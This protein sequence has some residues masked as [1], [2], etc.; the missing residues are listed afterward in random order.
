MKY[1]FDLKTLPQEKMDRAGGKASS[2]SL[3]MKN[4]KTNIPSGY[5]ITADGFRDGKLTD[6]ASEELNQTIAKLDRLK[7][8]AV[9]SSA[10]GEDGE[11]N[12]FAGQY[13]TLTDVIVPKIRDAVKQVAASAKSERVEEYKNRN[14]AAGEGIGIVIQE[15]V[16][17]DFAGVIFTSDIITGRDDKIVGNY[18]H[19]EGEKLVS[20]SEN[21]EEFRIGVMN[22]SYEGNPELAPYA[23]L[24][25]KYTLAIK[26]FYG[27]PMDI[28]WAVSRGKTYILQARPITTLRRIDP[29]TYDVNGTRSGYKLLTKTNVGEIF[30]KPV[31]PMTFSVLEKIND[32]LGLPDWLDCICGQEYMN[33]SVMCSLMV[34]FGKSREKAYEAVRE[35]VGEIPEGVE[36]PVSPFD[37]KAFMR[38]IRALLFPK[39]KSTLSKKEKHEMVLNLDRIADDLIIEVRKI[40]D[41]TA[42]MNYWDN[43]LVKYLN[44]GLAS[45]MT[46]S[47]TSLVPLF[48]TR[49]KIA[50][51]AGE[52]MANRL[53]TGCV[54][55]LDCMKP[56]LLLE[57][58]ASG[59]MTREEYISACG[60]RCAD[61]M[62]LMASRPYEDPT[63]PDALLKDLNASSS[64]LHQMQ[65]N[66]QKAY[67]EAV[68]EFKQKYPSKAKWFDKEIAKFIHANAFREDIRSKGV[69][70][71]CVFREYILKAGELNGLGDD[72]FMLSYDEMFALLKGDKTAL[73]YIP[74]R[75]ASL[76]KYNSYPGFPNLVVG[77]FDPDA[78]MA[79][80]GRRYDVFVSDRVGSENV[81]SDVK[82]FAG[83]AGVVTGTVRV[84]EDVSQIDEII[85]G[86]ILV[87][88]ATNIGWTVAF[89]KVSAIVTDI[90]APLS[91]AAIVAREFGIPAV[92]GC[93]NAT[94]VLKTGD[95]VT[96]DGSKGTVVIE[97]T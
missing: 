54:G 37:K 72:I 71:F 31:S 94:S 51:I 93:R 50:K 58:V 34:S 36:I 56:M 65:E 10:I 67:E 30:M 66:Q 63:F 17:P 48:G 79:D 12:S 59:A 6:E 73:Q 22:Y 28:E 18:V 70:I 24:L 33:I 81:S 53:C 20:G 3:M 77:R 16:K 60:H 46:E 14:D 68:S 83:A 26:A 61:E 76:D 52:D 29:K 5:V 84:V 96:V 9:R 43:V 75:K 92:V 38:K 74:A 64:N 82:G 25:R 49:K 23:G 27:M 40:N 44:D 21:A 13:E 69:R 19:G 11:N 41:S 32:I 39:N 87:T 8:Y 4:L 62:E 47:G 2:L 42:L 1:I 86:E 90:G 45:I 95:V 35:L 97:K 15:F 85:E 91:H 80:P 89:H 57:D 7:T 55:I 78:W 88:R